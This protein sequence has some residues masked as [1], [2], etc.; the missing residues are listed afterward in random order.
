MNDQA[1]PASKP[2][3]ARLPRF[4]FGTGLG[5]LI[6]YVIIFLVLS[7]LSPV[8]FSSR[9]LL[10]L[11]NSVAVL[12]IIAIFATM[13]MIGGGLDLSVGANT[14][15]I[16][17]VAASLQGPLTI[18]GGAVVALLVGLVIGVT[19]GLLVTEIGINPLITTLGMLSV[20]RGLAFVFS[21]G[22]SIV[23][24]D[25]SFGQ[26]GR[27]YIAGIPTPV[28]VVTIIFVIAVL[29][30]RYTTYGR[31][32]YAIGGNYRASYLASLP[33]KRYRITSYIL[34]GLFAAVAGIFL[35]SRLGAAAPQASDG[36]ELSVVAAVILGGT[37]LSGGKGNL[38]GT[39]IGVLILGTLNNGLTLLSVNAY[40]QQIVQ[41]LILL[42]AVA[43][44]Q[45]RI[46]NVGRALSAIKLRLD[47][48]R[49]VRGKSL[50]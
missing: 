6:I 21:G 40:Y 23:V 32:M 5:L 15:L 42:L 26:I 50:P 14:A 16:G 18:W 30:M 22:L 2:L 28:I 35:T 41:G 10:N 9:N 4:Q 1:I 19:N 24:L 17:V 46:G 20:V 8:F 36:M 33:V 45:L 34:S 29:V 12:G 39:L 48:I 7:R 25:V 27:G 44:D 38:F 43:L 47:R 11:L 31:A 37:S 13:L 3:G 49:P